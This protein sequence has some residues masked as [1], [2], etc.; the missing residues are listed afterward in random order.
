M[1]KDELAFMDFSGEPHKSLEN[2]KLLAQLSARDMTAT[3]MHNL[4]YFTA[5]HSEQRILGKRISMLTVWV[6]ADV[7]TQQGADLLKN[8]LL[9]MVK[10]N[11]NQQMFSLDSLFVIKFFL[12]FIDNR[13]QQLVCVLLSFQIL[14]V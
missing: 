13:N 2:I 11:K 8:A 12:L 14:K 10:L 7:T 9:H 3:L 6:I 1:T 4:K 5:K